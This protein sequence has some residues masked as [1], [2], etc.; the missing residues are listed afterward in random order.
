MFGLEY[1]PAFIKV[2]FNIAFAIVTA[3]P[4]YFAWN[5]L[6]NIYFKFLPEILWQLPYWDIVAFFLVFT[7][8]GDQIAKLTPKLISI[9]QDVR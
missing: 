7:Y 1:I 3:I 5:C 2:F 8:L 6:A 4:F 9:S